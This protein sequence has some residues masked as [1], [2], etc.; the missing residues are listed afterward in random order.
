M[1]RAPGYSLDLGISEG[2]LWANGS[3]SCRSNCAASPVWSRFV[4]TSRSAFAVHTELTGPELID[5]TP[6]MREDILLNLPPYPHCDREGDRVCKAAGT[7]AARPDSVI[8]E[9]P[10]A[11]DELDKLKFK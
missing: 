10:P 11:W 4:T 3:L 8:K 2:A 1:H 7:I 5:L 6:F 9:A